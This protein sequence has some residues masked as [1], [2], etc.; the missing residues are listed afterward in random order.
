MCSISVRCCVHMWHV[1]NNKLNEIVLCTEW[2]LILLFYC[3]RTNKFPESSDTPPV[4]LPGTASCFSFLF[5]VFDNIYAT[6]YSS[7]CVTVGLRVCSVS[8][9]ITD[10]NKEATC[11][12][13]DDRCST[14]KVF[15]SCHSIERVFSICLPVEVMR[16]SSNYLAIS[17]VQA[18]YVCVCRHIHTTTT[19]KTS[20][21][22]TIRE[23]W[24]TVPLIRP[25]VL[26]STTLAICIGGDS[27][28][29]S[30]SLFIIIMCTSQAERWKKKRRYSGPFSLSFLYF[31]LSWFGQISARAREE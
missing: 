16:I 6:I 11:N 29:S 24:K 28:S 25:S 20:A 15:F 31:R 21:N 23:G 8:L 30:S 14:Q 9:S 27:S 22:R 19:T 26:N 18:A 3:S 10:D 12:K 4:Y 17:S 5:I 2:P 1:Y 7:A 13:N